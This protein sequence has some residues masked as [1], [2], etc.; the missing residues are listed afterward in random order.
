[1]GPG[2]QARPNAGMPR[3]TGSR[4]TPTGPGMAVFEVYGAQIS[5]GL[6]GRETAMRLH[7]L[8]DGLNWVAF[9]FAPF[10]LVVKG[11]WLEFLLWLAAMIALAFLASA[12]YPVAGWLLALLVSLYL[13]LEG[14]RLVAWRLMRKG[15][16]LHGVVEA[17]SEE[18]AELRWWSAHAGAVAP[19]A[20]K[21]G[22]AGTAEVKAPAIRNPAAREPDQGFGLF[23]GD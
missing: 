9:A 2:A 19:G 12:G 23:A 17:D 13:L 3:I 21:P 15:F 20:A 16:M 22:T 7:F 8:R 4:S 14:N 6:Q 11:L 1:M 10:W 18:T 5:A